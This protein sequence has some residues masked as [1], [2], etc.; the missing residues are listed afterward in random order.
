M[1]G[2]KEISFFQILFVFAMVKH[3]IG[4][5]ALIQALARDGLSASAIAA[6]VGVDR[7]TVL[8]WK[9]RTN[10]EDLIRCGRPAK[11]TAQTRK[12]ITRKLTRKEGASQ[13]SIAAQYDV[14]HQTIGRH[15]KQLGLKPLHRQKKPMLTQQQQKKRV[16]FAKRH[17]DEDWEAVLFEDEK[18]FEVGHHPNRKNDVVYAYRADQVPPLPAVKHPAKLNVAA[19]VSSTGR[20]KLH[21]FEENLTGELYKKILKRTILPAANHIFGNNPWTL[22][23]DNDPKH[24]SGTV[25]SF[26]DSNQ[27]KYFPKDDWPPNSPDFNIMENVWAMLL[28]SINKHPPRTTAQLKRQLRYQWKNLAQEKISSAVNSMPRRLRAAQKAKG[29][30]TKY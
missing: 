28:D 24:T 25:T 14:S 15:A 19:A 20:S 9:D 16:D 27:V 5:R 23:Q 2:S 17:K 11:L 8:L 10:C 21:I 26:L 7:K 30:Y 6:K 29:G 13:R 18:T 1:K 12:A 22:L 3:D 4:K